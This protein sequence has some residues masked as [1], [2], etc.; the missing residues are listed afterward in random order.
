MSNYYITVGANS[1]SFDAIFNERITGTGVTTTNF[2]DNNTDVGTKYTN[3]IPQNFINVPP[4]YGDV[5]L[6]RH[7]SVNYN[8]NSIDIS[9][10]L[11][12]K[13]IQ[14]TVPNS[15]TESIPGWCTTIQ[16][17]IIGGGGG[18]GNF[19]SYT[20][21]GYTTK[22]DGGGGG[23]GAYRYISVP[24]VSSVTTFS[25]VVGSGGTAGG[26][27]GVDSNIGYNYIHYIAK[28]GNGGGNAS[29]YGDNG[30]GGT[31]GTIASG[32]VGKNGGNGK[33]GNNDDPNGS[34]GGNG[35]FDVTHQGI[36]NSYGRG[37]NGG[38]FQTNGTV[39]P[40]AGSNG[41]VRVYFIR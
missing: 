39:P 6:I 9:Q 18:G 4:I 16:A 29:S 7:T 13:F 37:G 38:Y 25:V 30:D 8:Y 32:E 40:Q 36:S 19:S 28:K 21:D 5:P 41:Y 27:E 2:F 3:I 33:E 17:I 15:Y 1:Y 22:G 11:L 14:Y 35:G 31:G 23:G 20:Y 24:T 10:Y 26:N 12:P 34:N